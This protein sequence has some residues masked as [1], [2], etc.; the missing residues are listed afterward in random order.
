MA[1]QRQRQQSSEAE[2][3]AV[4]M[5]VRVNQKSH[6]LL[7]AKAVSVRLFILS[8]VVYALYFVGSKHQNIV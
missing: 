8:D 5:S 7:K 3:A 2:A 1:R 4:A 6:E